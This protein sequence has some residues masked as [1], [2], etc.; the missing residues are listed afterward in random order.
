MV[1]KTLNWDSIAP[2]VVPKPVKKKVYLTKAGNAI[3]TTSNRM[4]SSDPSHKIEERMVAGS[5]ALQSVMRDVFST[6]SEDSDNAN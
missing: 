3:R 4:N 6:P 5:V 1:D 2:W